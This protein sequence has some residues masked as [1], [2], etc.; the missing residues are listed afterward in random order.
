ML[1]ALDGLEE[2][3]SPGKTQPNSRLYFFVAKQSLLPLLAVSQS[4]VLNYPTMLASSSIALNECIWSLG[5]GRLFDQVEIL[6]DFSSPL[7]DEAV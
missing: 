6:M 2:H 7:T 5:F 3:I 1:T 4:H